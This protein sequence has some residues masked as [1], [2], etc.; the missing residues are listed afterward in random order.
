MSMLLYTTTLLQTPLVDRQGLITVPWQRFLQDLYMRVGESNAPTIPEIQAQTEL[1]LG[2]QTSS[3][4]AMLMAEIVALQMLPR[5]EAVAALSLADLA[6]S[7][8]H[9]R[10]EDDP[11]AT[12]APGVLP[13]DL[14]P[15]EEG[16]I[17]DF[18]LG[19]YPL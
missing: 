8:Q 13:D 19:E 9:H 18:S 7:M 6:P 11:G 15:R 3:H 17:P 1:E 4:L 2:G 10:V 5:F 16:S 12:P 14:A